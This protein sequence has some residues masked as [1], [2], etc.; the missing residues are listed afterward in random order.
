MTDK[1]K[2]IVAET[3]KEIMEGG[4]NVDILMECLML[5]SFNYDYLECR[6]H[7]EVQVLEEYL[8]AEAPRFAAFEPE[9]LREIEAAIKAEAQERIK[10]ETLTYVVTFRLLVVHI[11]LSDIENDGEYKTPAGN[12]KVAKCEEIFTMFCSM[13]F[14]EAEIMRGI[15]ATAAYDC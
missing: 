10:D 2:D 7:S 5:T 8:Q 15:M 13:C 4:E 9:E 1:M 14:M 6:K 11:I 3:M 12:S